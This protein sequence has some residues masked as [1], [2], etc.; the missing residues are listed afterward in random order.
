LYFD[1]FL[2]DIKGKFKRSFDPINNLV[3]LAK[4]PLKDDA[5]MR[6]WRTPNSPECFLQKGRKKKGEGRVDERRRND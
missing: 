6:L 4:M 1:D 3:P 2:S 5:Q